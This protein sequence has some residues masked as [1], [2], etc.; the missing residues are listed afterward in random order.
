MVVAV[1]ITGSVNQ[2]Q[3]AFQL[4]CEIDGGSFREAFYVCV[5]QPHVPFL[6][7][8]VVVS[9][10]RN[11]GNRDGCRVQIWMFEDDNAWP[12]RVDG[13]AKRFGFGYFGG[14]TTE[15]EN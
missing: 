14:R 2:Q 10:V 4:F 12:V 11:R 3:I 1:V 5:G 8:R 7:D 6:I 13:Q 9:L 15:L